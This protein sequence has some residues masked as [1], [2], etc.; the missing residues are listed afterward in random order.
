MRF[1]IF[2]IFLIFTL[3]LFV[4]REISKI[5]NNKTHAECYFNQRI[6]FKG[7]ING[8]KIEKFGQIIS[9]N[10]VNGEKYQLVR[11]SCSFKLKK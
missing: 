7:Y 6:A 4:A 9:I 5:P 3:G 11:P 10:T 2:I 1:F 8:Y